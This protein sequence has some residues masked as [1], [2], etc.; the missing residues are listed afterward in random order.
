MSPSLCRKPYC[1]L[2]G[3]G[4]FV[5]GSASI[6]IISGPKNTATLLG[7]HASFECSVTG[8]VFGDNVVY[9]KVRLFASSEMGVTEIRKI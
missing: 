4:F 6:S 1:V 3:V 2:K 7:G 8:Q 9:R 5:L